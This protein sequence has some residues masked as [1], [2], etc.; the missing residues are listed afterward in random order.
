MYVDLLNVRLAASEVGLFFQNGKPAVDS[1]IEYGRKKIHRRLG[2]NADTF[3][4]RI[5]HTET[6]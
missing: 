6:P 4:V 1:I 5:S 3:T 2:V